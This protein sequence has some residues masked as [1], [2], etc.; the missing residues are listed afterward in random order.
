MA[1]ELERLFGLPLEEF[2]AARTEAARRLRK[3]GRAD[4]ASELQSLRKPT[5]AVW[6]LNQAAR[7]EPGDVRALVRAAERLRRDPAEAD[8]DFRAALRDVVRD[9][10]SALR[11][12]GH[13]AT[14]TTVRRIGTTAHAAAVSEPEALVRGVLRDELEPTGFDVFAGAALPSPKAA[15]RKPASPGKTAPPRPTKASREAEA[16]ARRE[17]VAAA[18]KELTEARAEARRL[19]TEAA[20]AERQAAKAREA[21][22]RAEEEVRRAEERLDDARSS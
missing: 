6:A 4:E 20:S 21:A 5:A 3:E 7:R 19:A 8:R 16:K 15:A 17:R 13:A 2:I 10:E 12:S 18:R 1:D 14:D 9:A 22:E 11:E